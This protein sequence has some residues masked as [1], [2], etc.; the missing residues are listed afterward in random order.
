MPT[1]GSVLASS[2][3]TVRSWPFHNSV[4]KYELNTYRLPSASS[5]FPR[6][7]HDRAMCWINSLGS[8]RSPVK[9]VSMITRVACSSR[10]ILSRT[11][12]MV[13]SRFSLTVPS[14]TWRSRNASART[15]ELRG[16]QYAPTTVVHQDNGPRAG[17]RPRGCSNSPVS[18]SIATILPLFPFSTCRLTRVS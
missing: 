3:S 10:E 2:T 11:D 8:V 9:P 1:S 16:S 12:G 18:M 6:L 15:G 5:A 17:R 7:C 13:T 14:I 4:P